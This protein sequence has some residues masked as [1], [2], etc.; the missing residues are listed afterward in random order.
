MFLNL[1]YLSGDN[2]YHFYGKPIINLT[3]YQIELFS[4]ASNFKNILSEFGNSIPKNIMNDP[5]KLLEYVELNRNYKKAFP[6]D[7]EGEGGGGRGIMGATKDDLETLGIQ[8]TAN[9]KFSQKLKEKGKL[10][11]KDLM[12]M[13]GENVK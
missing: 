3:F 10:S 12:E 11:L 4:L 5:D 13:S 2:I 7:K 6:E 9:D 8:T 1:F